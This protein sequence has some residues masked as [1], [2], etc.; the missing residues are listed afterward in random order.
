MKLRTISTS[1]V[2]L[3]ILFFGASI[4]QFSVLD[5]EFL[6]TNQQILLPQSTILAFDNF[7][8][9]YLYS[10]DPNINS[11]KTD[12]TISFSYFDISSG[13]DIYEYYILDLF[14]FGNCSDFDIAI[15]INYNYTDQL[16]FG[17]F[18][19]VLS[20]SYDEMGN[21]IGELEDGLRW[22]IGYTTIQ[23]AWDAQGGIFKAGSTPNDVWE[24]DETAYGASGT[25]GYAHYYL[26]RHSGII[27]CTIVK[28]DVVQIS[29]ISSQPVT[30]PLCDIRI[31][32]TIYT[33]ETSFATG[34]FSNFSAYLTVEEDIII[35]PPPPETITITETVTTTLG[36]GI[37]TSSIF[38]AISIGLLVIK[39]LKY[40]K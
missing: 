18:Q 35:T 8:N 26:S 24:L 4:S 25:L 37:F 2:F 13:P 38:I 3:I 33:S 39:R 40:R 28:D 31:G 29:Y 11:V 34:I 36:N 5:G 27:N 30:K 9:L 19:I 16:Q 12:D 20:S 6:D 17:R 14:P 22:D 23:D 10:D 21:Y 15:T 1:F 7:S 32:T